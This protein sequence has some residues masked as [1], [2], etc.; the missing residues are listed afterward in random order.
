LDLVRSR[1]GQ[2]LLENLPFPSSA[3]VSILDFG[4]GTGE[5]VSLLWESL[6]FSKIC[7]TDER[8]VV[9][10]AR[11]RFPTLSSCFIPLSD[12][13]GLYDCVLTS[14]SIDEFADPEET[15]RKMRSLARRWVIATAR[16]EKFPEDWWQKRGFAAYRDFTTEPYDG[17]R[18]VAIYDDKGQGWFPERPKVLIGSPVRQHPD[19][20][21]EFLSSL[22][23]LDTSGFDPVFLFVD[24]NDTLAASRQLSEFAK[25]SLAP[26]IIW[27]T[28][29]VGRYLCD[30]RTHRWNEQLIRRVAAFKDAIFEFALQ[31][32]MDSVLLV[33]SDLVL[34]PETVRRLLSHRLGIVA[35]V[36]WTRF[37]PEQPPLPNVWLH[38]S[39]GLY[40]RLRSEQISLIEVQRRMD[41]FI[42]AMRKEPGVYRVH[43]FG[44]CTLFPRI[45][46]EK[47]IRFEEI[48]GLTFWGEDRHLA[49][50]AEA[51]G[52][53]SFADSSLPPF[54]IYR[55]DDLSKVPLYREICRRG[56]SPREFVEQV[57][58][59]AA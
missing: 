25:R 43:G 50:R 5:A 14:R 45:A 29:I 17:A 16:A 4:C 23:E 44:A 6:P 18:W 24:N 42:S 52:I 9:D 54:H 40:K 58:A 56:L 48:K 12:K 59:I 37:M 19:I 41:A 47:G 57:I 27:R 49:I 15:L 36:F 35:M 39:Y 22:S 38:D 34:H 1:I 20:L 11:S 21:R 7:G 2:L 30:E 55:Q 3:A 53:P 13:I 32:E 46:L 10:M 51:L 26:V 8:S 28:P 33:D 31:N